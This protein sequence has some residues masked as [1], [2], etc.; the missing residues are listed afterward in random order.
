MI[1]DEIVI[2]QTVKWLESVIIE[3]NICPFARREVE[4]NRVRYKVI[5][6]NDIELCLQ[7]LIDECIKLDSNDDIETCLIIFPES[8]SDFDNYLNFVDI[9]NDLLIDQGYEGVF[10]LA[11]FHPDYCF[12][13]SK[14]DDPANYTN[15]SAYPM[16]HLIREESLE[17]ALKNYP[18]PELIPKNNIKLT[19][20]FGLQKMQALLH[21]CYDIDN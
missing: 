20:Q 9:S 4:R 1:A 16:L 8:L 12:A 11:T 7:L 17:K 19:R 13:D 10:Q 14:F 15:R 18:H 2:K 5:R 3:H 6:D 21:A